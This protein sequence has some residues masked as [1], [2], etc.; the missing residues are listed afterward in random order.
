MASA[1]QVGTLGVVAVSVEDI[2]VL[3]EFRNDVHLLG[4]IW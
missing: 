4:L 1:E 2:Y 3:T